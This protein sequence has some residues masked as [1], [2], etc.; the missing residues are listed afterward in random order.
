MLASDML[1]YR[2]EQDQ[3][4]FV[5]T[6]GPYIDL[7][8]S[9]ALAIRG[10]GDAVDDPSVPFTNI[11]IWDYGTDTSRIPFT[12]EALAQEAEEWLIDNRGDLGSYLEQSI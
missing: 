5:W 1:I 3:V 2:D 7:H 8:W 4:A 11:N 6:G 10:V 12:R 9:D